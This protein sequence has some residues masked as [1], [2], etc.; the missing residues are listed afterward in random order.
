MRQALISPCILFALTLVEACSP[1]PTEGAA[2]PK[3]ASPAVHGSGSG[4]AVGTQV[5][6]AKSIDVMMEVALD[7]PSPDL[8]ARAET[9]T[10][11]VLSSLGGA[12]RDV[13]VAVI[14]G[15]KARGGG[16]LPIAPNGTAAFKAIDFELSPKDVLL[17]AAA[18]GCSLA[19]SNFPD[20][21]GADGAH[22]LACKQDLSSLGATSDDL[23]HAWL[24]A[25]NPMRGVAQATLRAN[26]PRIYVIISN[27]DAI[28]LDAHGF[29]ALAAAQTAEK[30]TLIVAA[31]LDA[32]SLSTCG[33][34]ATVAPR[35]TA[36]VNGNRGTTTDFC[37][38]AASTVAASVRDAVK[39]AMP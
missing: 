32:N 29:G 30:V 8:V 33:A 12:G 28:F 39:A 9:V 15:K 31:P 2:T 34:T 22:P 26:T 21:H 10:S 38:G 6:A 11:L 27:G 36:V 7:S 5:L 17:S 14:E 4:S 35:L 3:P 13:H 18:A 19:D 16:D 24:W 20:P 23:A 25:L 1:S 37:A